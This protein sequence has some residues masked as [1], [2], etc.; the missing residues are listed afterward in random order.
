[1]MLALAKVIIFVPAS[2]LFLLLV[3]FIHSVVETEPPTF[4][5]L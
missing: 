3:L 5:R 2:S 1:M 4:D